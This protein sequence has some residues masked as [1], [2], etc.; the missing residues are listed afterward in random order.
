MKLPQVM[1]LVFCKRLNPLTFSLE[2]LFQ[3]RRFRS[4]PTPPQYFEVYVALYSDKAEGLLE[5]LVRR[6]ETEEDIYHH[7]QWFRFPG[8]FV[9]QLQ[10]PIRK[11][12]FAAPGRYQFRL[13]FEGKELTVR[14][15]D[16]SREQSR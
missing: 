1:G 6:M 14:F 10:I 2:R 3:G 8:G 7:R 11:I 15:L 4:F 13:L 16:I 12:R 9:M 5:L